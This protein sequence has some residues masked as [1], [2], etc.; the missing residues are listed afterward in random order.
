MPWLRLVNTATEDAKRVGAVNVGLLTAVA[1]LR[2]RGI[3][4]SGTPAVA[5]VGSGAPC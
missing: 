4:E 5:F 3:G 2:I 1:L